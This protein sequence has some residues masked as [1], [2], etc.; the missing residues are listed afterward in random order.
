MITIVRRDANFGLWRVDC[1]DP[2]PTTSG[3]QRSFAARPRKLQRQLVS[4][5][6]RETAM[7]SPDAATGLAAGSVPGAGTESR[8]NPARTTSSPAQGC[9]AESRSDQQCRERECRQYPGLKATRASANTSGPDST[10]TARPLVKLQ[11]RQTGTAPNEENSFLL[12]DRTLASEPAKE[13]DPTVDLMSRRHPLSSTRTSG[14][15]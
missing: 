4:C 5:D 2:H 10:S 8:A 7:I 1:R 9:A 6:G 14:R 11:N 12:P 15:R 13:N 3:L